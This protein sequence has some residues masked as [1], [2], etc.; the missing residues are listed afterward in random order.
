MENK[1]HAIAAGAFVVVVAALLVTLAVWLT[2]DSS[3]RRVY[4]IASQQGVTG[5]LPQAAVRYKGV[6]VGRVTAIALDSTAR[7]GVL[8]RL[9]VDSNVPVTASTFATLGFQGITGLSFIQLDDAGSSQ[10]ALQTSD[11]TPARIPMRPNMFS[12]LSEQGAGLL[13]QADEIGQRVNQL[14]APHNQ[15]VMVEAVGRIGQAAASFSQLAQH[16]DQALVKQTAEL[17][18]PQL[19]QDVSATL[20]TM[21]TSTERLGQTADAMRKSA[22]EFRAVAQRMNEPGGTLD[23]IARGSEALA[24]TNQNANAALLPRLNRTADETARAV[25]QMNRAVEGIGDNPQSLLLGRGA[26]TPGPGEAGFTP[27]KPH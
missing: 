18:L 5:L 1:S 8:V 24:T 16:A 22:E 21:Q 14:L 7:G 25:R 3:E 4:E 27:P 17:N 6:L 20:K 11:A 12:R 19:V 26:A 2:R 13:T 10:E 9:N 15:Q 23:K